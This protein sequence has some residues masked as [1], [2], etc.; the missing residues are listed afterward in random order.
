M[1]LSL[2]LSFSTKTI[3]QFCIYLQA[4]IPVFYVFLE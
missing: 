2:Q 1:D 4:I 3:F